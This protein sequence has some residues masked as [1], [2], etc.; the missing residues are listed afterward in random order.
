MFSGSVVGGT[1]K[2]HPEGVDNEQVKIFL[3]SARTYIGQEI[4]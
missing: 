1:A 4:T 2:Y 3:M